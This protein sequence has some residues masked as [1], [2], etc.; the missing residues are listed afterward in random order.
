MSEDTQQPL[1]LGIHGFG[2]KPGEDD[3][4][5]SWERALTEGLRR[6]CGL[7]EPIA[8]RFEMVYWYDNFGGV[9]VAHDYPPYIEST[10]EGPFPRYGAD[11]WLRQIEPFLTGAANGLEVVGDAL[12]RSLGL[13]DATRKL[14][15]LVIE[16]CRVY[17]EEHEKRAS[18]QDELRDAILRHGERPI[19]VLAH[20]VGSV[21]AYETLRR[22]ERSHPEARPVTLFTT[23]SP[24]GMP[25]VTADMRRKRGPNQVPRGVA[26]WVNFADRRD[27]I[28]FDS[29][30]RDDYPAV[31][32]GV[33]IE[34]RLV[35]N[36]YRGPDGE[37][38]HHAVYGYLRAPE[39]SERLRDFLAA[40][41]GDA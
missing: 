22:M 24:L 13:H 28:T 3:L 14:I 32:S 34:D 30:L 27:P 11:P 39:L 26:R 17:H 35:I 19:L 7:G 2:R 8:G 29:R 37:D 15:E 16:D 6:N 31:E 40:E 25:F 20:S 23:G 38:D 10:G 12:M 4:E 18:A 41:A 36:A 9:P 1:V 33:E 21:I 5:A